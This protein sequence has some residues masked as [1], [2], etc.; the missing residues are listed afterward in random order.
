[1]TIYIRNN[2]ASPANNL[3]LSLLNGSHLFT[4]DYF[5]LGTLD[6][7]TSGTTTVG[8]NVA[9]NLK[10]GRYLVQIL[11]TYTDDNGVS[12]NSSLPLE[13]TIY[14]PTSALSFKTIGIIV[15]VAIIAVVVYWWYTIRRK[16]AKPKPT[17]SDR[18]LES[19]WKAPLVEKQ[20]NASDLTHVDDET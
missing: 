2:G 17:I 4:S 3:T 9:S 6:P 15:A 14:A 12:Y 1:M 18:A 16:G 5:G 20:S 10:G 19:T 11:A 8:V 7:S 13:I